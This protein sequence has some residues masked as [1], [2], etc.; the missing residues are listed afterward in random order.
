MK[1]KSNQAEQAFIALRPGRSRDEIIG[2]AAK[3]GK[4]RC[5]KEEEIRKR[6]KDGKGTSRKGNESGT[7][8]KTKVQAEA[9]RVES[10][11]RA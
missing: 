8:D 10:L 4:G 3:T 7:R 5:R 6:K 9:S 11:P 2:K 1:A